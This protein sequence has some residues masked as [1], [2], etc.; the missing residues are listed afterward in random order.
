VFLFNTV[1][2]R[3]S[4]ELVQIQLKHRPS[5]SELLAVQEDRSSSARSS[6]GGRV[7]NDEVD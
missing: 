3:S 5:G 7:P 2:M 6:G 1:Y 4:C